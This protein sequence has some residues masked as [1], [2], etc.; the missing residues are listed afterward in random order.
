VDDVEA[1]DQRDAQAGAGDGLAL[2]AVGQGRVPDEE[3]RAD[4]AV[5]EF[6]LH[7]GGLPGHGASLGREGG[8]GVLVGQFTG[9]E[10]EVLG[11]LAGLLLDG[12]PGEQIV[13]PLLGGEGCVLV[14]QLGHGR[15]NLLVRG[16]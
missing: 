9:A 15:P 4:V 16:R 1:E 7:H 5:V 10:I 2:E 12:Q 14:G 13:R 8:Q 6:V 11:E 3:Q